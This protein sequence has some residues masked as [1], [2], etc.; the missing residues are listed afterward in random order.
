M[1]SKLPPLDKEI[2]RRTDEVLHYVWDPIGV[3]TAPEARDEYYGYLPQVFAL[4]KAKVGAKTI[5]AHL[6]DIATQRMGLTANPTNDLKAAELLV[7]WQE[8]ID[9]NITAG[10]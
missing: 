8:V 7:H 5:A 2:Y 4:L 1:G 6:T 3:S 10:S 9:G